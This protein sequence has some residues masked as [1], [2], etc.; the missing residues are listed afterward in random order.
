MQMFSLIMLDSVIRVN[1]KNY[2][3]ILKELTLLGE[4]KYT[5][6]KNKTEN[7][8]NDDLNSSSSDNESDNGFNDSF[9]ED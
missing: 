8:I 5:I 9:V 1:K 6:K 7:A 3:H 4:C 2:P